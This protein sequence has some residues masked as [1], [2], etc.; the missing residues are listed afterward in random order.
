MIRLRFCLGHR[1]DT[2][3]HYLALALFWAPLACGGGCGDDLPSDPDDDS[4]STA[5]GDTCSPTV[6]LSCPVTSTAAPPTSGGNN[7]DSTPPGTTDDGGAGGSTGATTIGIPDECQLSADCPDG[8][9]CVSPFVPE[10]GPEGRQPS[11]C[12][13]EC[14]VL[15]DELRWC[16]DADSCCNPQAVC[17]DRGYCELPEEEVDGSTGGSDD[18]GSGSSGGTG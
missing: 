11:E 10:W 2:M 9:F 8:Q 15:Q 3:R 16:Y 1:G 7:D 18:G 13:S 17:T 14:V 5:A 12:V 6:N 4:T